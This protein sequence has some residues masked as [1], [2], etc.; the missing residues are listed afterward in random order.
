MLR[1]SSPQPPGTLAP[2]VPA[3]PWIQFTS[4]E[5]WW[6]EQE[7]LFETSVT[8]DLFTLRG[9]LLLAWLVCVGLSPLQRVPDL[10]CCYPERKRYLPRWMGR[11]WSPQGCVQR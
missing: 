5:G 1:A 10:S 6:P 11:K 2:A 9:A 7:G 8:P 4:P 3:L